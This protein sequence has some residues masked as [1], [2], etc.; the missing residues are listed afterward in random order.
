[1]EVEGLFSGNSS[2]VRWAA[3]GEMMLLARA[4]RCTQNAGIACVCFLGWEQP[5]AEEGSATVQ[6]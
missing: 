6:L 2:M 3:A 1:V 5:H 4:W